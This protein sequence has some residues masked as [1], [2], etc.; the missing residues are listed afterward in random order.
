MTNPLETLRKIKGASWSELRTRGGQAF[1]A[2]AEQVGLSAKLPSDEEFFEKIKSSY[3]GPDGIDAESLRR[4]FYRNGEYSFFAPFREDEEIAETFFD[5]FGRQP[6][7]AILEKADDL[8]AGRFDIFGHRGLQAGENVDW[9]FEPVSGKHSPL[10]HWKQFDDLSTEETGDKK[11]LW[12]LNRHQ[13]FFT[14]GAAY[15]FTGNEKYGETFAS[16]LESWIETNPPGM[17]I[18]WFS[19]LE[20]AFRAISWI[21]AFHFFRNSPSFSDELF[22]KAL[23]MLY[24]HGRHVEK[25]LSTYYSPNTHLTGEAL[26]LFYLGTQ[27]PFFKRSG[28]WKQHGEDVLCG[29]L[30]RQILS[31]G[32]YFEQSTWYHRYTVDFY[33][34]FFI[35]R[36][37]SGVRIKKFRSEKLTG[38][39][40]SL[41]NFLMYISRPDR[42][43]PLIGDDD[44]GRCLPIS[45]AAPDDFSA[46]LS[47]GASMFKRSDMKFT[48]GSFAE[49]TFWLLG[50]DGF[51]RFD[52]IEPVKPEKRS[53]AFETTGYF[54]MRDGWNDSDNLL[55]VDCGPLGS[56]SGGHGH[57]DS[58]SFDLSV[59][60]I[61]VF[62]D[63]G[64]YTY[65]ESEE[66]RNHF[67]TS[68]AHNT[69]TIDGKSQS[70]PGAKFGWNSKAESRLESWITQPRFDFFEGSHDGFKRLETAPAIHRRSILFLKDDYW[71]IRD[72]VETNGEHDY[73]I[74]FQFD[75][76]LFPK[77]IEDKNGQAFVETVL[78]NGLKLR[79]ITLGDNG[80]WIRED[81]FVSKQFAAK[82]EA[83][84]MVYRSSGIGRQEFFTF[85]L[86]FDRSEPEPEV[87]E[88]DII[89]GRAFVIKYRSYSDLLVLSDEDSVVK[90]ELFNSNFDFLWARIGEGDDSPEEFVMVGGSHFSLGSVEI[91][92]YKDRV[93]F[94]T[95]RR[96][97]NQLNVKLP[98]NILTVSLR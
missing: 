98:D 75:S 35:L 31:D 80:G 61:P 36:S 38:K 19:S 95:A 15:A 56:L 4:E 32:G 27:L 33:T 72:L 8:A 82:H 60:G 58:L 91:F 71:I 12:E 55:V 28:E 94:A 57:A 48:A 39:L 52:E 20:V 16:H 10:K 79:Q 22:L 6:A 9:H 81:S 24:L 46:C 11:I 89:N 53:V 76:E 7:V 14:L 47:T 43:T 42:T 1:S 68:A 73:R 29:E 88:V 41:L 13:H 34:Q 87:N 78:S 62:V 67:R 17:G 37:L 97:G 50:I 70:S 26:G 65:H 63:P 30:D 93:D 45:N 74:N 25:Y 23:K 64:T 90:T 96:F 49:E 59:G 21:W 83:V 2:L 40:Q 92:K 44:G 54:A 18:N 69:L 86:P 84:K 51:R 85:L 3:F 5:V 66:L 77:I